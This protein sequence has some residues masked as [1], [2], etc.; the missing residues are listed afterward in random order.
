L[1]RANKQRGEKSHRW[2]GGKTNENR[3]LR[4]SLAAKMWR[5]KVFA[6][7]DYTCVKCGQRGGTLTADHIKPW[8]LYPM[9]RFDVD[10]GRT[11]CRECHAKEP[12]TGASLVRLM[13]S[14]R[15]RNGGVQLRLL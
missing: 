8:A 11:L 13:N 12:T 14:E 9:L 6:R 15:K 3:I 7:D 10:N 2:Q 4:N 1:H 5:E